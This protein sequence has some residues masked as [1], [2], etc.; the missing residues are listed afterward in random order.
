M[1]VEEVGFVFNKCLDFY[2][3]GELY[4]V[5]FNGKV[6]RFVTGFVICE[7]GGE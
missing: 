5:D 3:K 6:D 7:I 4:F 2:F 1:V